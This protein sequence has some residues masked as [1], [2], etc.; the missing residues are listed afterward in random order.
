MSFNGA[1]RPLRLIIRSP[2]RRWPAAFQELC[3]RFCG[4][5]F[6]DELELIRLHHWEIRASYVM[7]QSLNTRYLHGRERLDGKLVEVCLYPAD[8]G[9]DGTRT[10]S[11]AGVPMGHEHESGGFAGPMGEQPV[12]ERVSAVGEL[13]RS[14][15]DR[16]VPMGPRWQKGQAA[17]RRAGTPPR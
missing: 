5:Y 3:E 17:A 8:C 12:A 7:R 1:A 15:V 2:D 10:V 9:I 4:L 6:D 13:G 16:G 14:G 11:K